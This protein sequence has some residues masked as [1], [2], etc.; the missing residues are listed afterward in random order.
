MIAPFPAAARVC[1][2]VVLEG[3]TRK[4]TFA[5]AAEPSTM[6][7]DSAFSDFKSPRNS[8]THS[9]IV[10]TINGVKSKDQPGDA[11]SVTYHHCQVFY[12]RLPD[13]IPSIVVQTD[14]SKYLSRLPLVSCLSL[15]R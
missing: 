15:R 14:V 3:E 1:A 6:A 13:A 7:C 5:A 8:S 9:S 10:L 11:S 2:F 4:T 12:Q